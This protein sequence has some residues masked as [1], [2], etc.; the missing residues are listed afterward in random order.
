MRFTNIDDCKGRVENLLNGTSPVPGLSLILSYEQCL[1]Y[2]GDKYGH[3]PIWSVVSAL[4]DWV[5]PLFLLLGNIT[6][7]KKRQQNF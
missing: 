6:Y 4:T 5:I 3:Y 2:C 1:E 7:S